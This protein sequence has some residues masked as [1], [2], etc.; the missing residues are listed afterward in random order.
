M[1]TFVGVGF[2]VLAEERPNLERAS[3]ASEFEQ[4]ITYGRPLWSSLKRFGE[5]ELW[6][7][8]CLKLQGSDSFNPYN[9]A[10]CFSVLASRLALRLVPAHWGNSPFF[11]E[12]KAFAEQT[13][14]R[15][16]RILTHVTE[17]ASMHVDSPS[18]PVLAIAASLIMVPGARQQ[19]QMIGKSDASNQYG[20][21]L[22]NFRERCLLS[23]HIPIFKGSDGE[24]ASRLERC[25][26]GLPA[27]RPAR[28][29]RF[30]AGRD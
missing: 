30:H 27:T 17:H 15:N 18:E 12:Q 23:R 3:D 16:M 22:E 20:R 9:T 6:A 21:I 29:R 10:Q 7:S 24:L 8:A 13:V 11:G 2:D 1:P 14:D 5:E 28:T 19:V 4:V 26:A 25:L